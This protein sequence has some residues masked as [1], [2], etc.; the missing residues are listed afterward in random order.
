MAE[1]SFA[2][3]VAVSV[4][5]SGVASVT[6]RIL[7]AGAL[8]YTLKII[9]ESQLGIAALA[10][11][12]FDSIKSVTELGLGAALVQEKDPERIQVDSLFWMTFLLSSVVY[13]LLYFI[14]PFVADFYDTPKLTLMIQ[15]YMIA[16]VIYAFY[17]IPSKL[18]MKELEF[19]QLAISDNLSLFLSAILMIYLAYS[20]FG[21]W[22][23]IL[24]ELANKVLKMVLCQF[25]MPYFPKF[26]YNYKKVKHLI[27]FGIYTTG[28]KFFSNFYMNA[29]YMII[30][31]VFSKEL[32][33]IYSF[34]YRLVFDTVKELSSVINRVAF[35]TFSKL[36]FELDRL[37]VYFYTISRASMLIVG[38]IMIVIGA[39]IDWIL[40]LV[41]YEKWMDAVPYMRIFVVVGIFQC[42]IT[43]LP[44]L[45]NAKGK[46]KLNFYYT[47][48]NFILLPTGFLIAAQFSM[49]AVALSWFIV[50]PLVSLVI[51]YYGA[52]LTETNFFSFAY[53]SF[54]AF[55]TL[56]PLA[57]FAVLVRFGADLI[58][59]ETSWLPVVLSTIIV[60]STAGI[61]IWYREQEIIQAIRR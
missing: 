8:F 13:V 9:T 59:P 40:P 29:D 30:G 16:I 15:V 52:E 46:A 21:A 26:H 53:N 47:T 5:Y 60:L 12:F 24:A 11:A 25:F 41:G 48:A 44:K 61:V 55:L 32:L 22:A 27:E 28:S 31:K 23:I 51:I 43:L 37:R 20:G 1:Q 42:L 2:N 14:A 34:A 45:L 35:P 3:R 36:Q 17:M 33:G 10:I 19:K 57:V 38:T 4:L 18:L 50:Y 7:N 39:Y 58:F 54:T 6:A 56:V 49:M